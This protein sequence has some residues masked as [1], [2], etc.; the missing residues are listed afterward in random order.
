M[1]LNPETII[2]GRLNYAHAYELR[3]IVRI[4]MI[5]TNQ[6]ST[7]QL[8]RILYLNL[9]SAMDSITNLQKNQTRLETMNKSMEQQLT[10]LSRYISAH[11]K[12][13]L[14]AEIK[15]IVQTHS[16][17]LSFSSKLF[18][19]KFSNDD[20]EKRIPKTGISTPNLFAKITESNN[21]DSKESPERERKV[22]IMKKSL[23]VHSGLVANL[24]PL[25]EETNEII[26]TI[27]GLGR[28]SENVSVNANRTDSINNLTKNDLSESLKEL[29]KKNAGFFA[30]THEQIR[31]E[32]LFEKQLKLNFDENLKKLDEKLK[33]QSYIDD[34][35]IFQ[36][37][38]CMSLNLNSKK[39]VKIDSG[40]VTPIT[41]DKKADSNSTI[42]HPLSDIDVEIKFDGQSTK[43]KQIRPLKP[44]IDNKT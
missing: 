34:L 5:R 9:Q 23:S 42:S 40:F 12:Q 4:E 21:K 37:R 10:L 32:R 13:D 28:S 36:G 14:P 41:P 43:L 31:Q 16:R 39:E 11:N 25:K 6:F 26:D 35:S 19:S 1:A 18:S 7:F 30:N 2:Y 3:I 17:K 27:K 8:K 44:Y 29:G 22:F 33:N 15:K 20:E 38:K 24:K